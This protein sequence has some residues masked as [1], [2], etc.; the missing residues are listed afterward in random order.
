MTQAYW[1]RRKREVEPV[2][3]LIQTYINGLQW[4]ATKRAAPFTLEE[5]MAWLGFSEKPV[6]V[7][8]ERPRTPEELE[9]QVELLHT[10]YTQIQ[11]ANG[12]V[13]G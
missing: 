10:M 11:Q 2:A 12:H 5:V 7:E 9:A 1:Q 6:P 8:P 3:L 4:D 13:K